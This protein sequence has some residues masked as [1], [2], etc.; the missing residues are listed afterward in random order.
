MQP[1]DEAVLVDA[2]VEV[3]K[4]DY[5]SNA[6]YPRGLGSSWCVNENL[7]VFLKVVVLVGNVPGGVNHLEFGHVIGGVVSLVSTGG[8]QDSA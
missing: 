4:P 2:E 6:V 5:V 1:L 8:V 3:L 7:D